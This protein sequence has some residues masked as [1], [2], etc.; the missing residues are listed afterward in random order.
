MVQGKVWQANLVYD[1]MTY[2]GNQLE[3]FSQFFYHFDA[4]VEQ[5]FKVKYEG[6]IYFISTSNTNG[7]L[8]NIKTEGRA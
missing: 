7:I 3:Q 4:P 2:L 1:S 6:Q 8:L 5:R